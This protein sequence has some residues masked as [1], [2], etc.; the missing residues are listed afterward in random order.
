MNEVKRWYVSPRTI[1]IFQR[2][3]PNSE[4]PPDFSGLVLASDYDALAQRCA[5]LEEQ[6]KNAWHAAHSES[7]DWAREYERR[8][9]A[10]AENDT[11]RAEVERMRALL[12][13]CADYL[14]TNELTSIGHGSILHQKMIDAAMEAHK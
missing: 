1:A 2:A 5:G 7:M 14:N 6:A 13:E 10:Q 3:D 8:M 9:D 11:L 4:I 12:A